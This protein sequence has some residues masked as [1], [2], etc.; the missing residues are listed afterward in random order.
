M[1][2]TTVFRV[3]KNKNYTTISNHHL[4]DKN[5][6]LKAKG[7]LTLILSL[8]PDWDMTLKGLVSLSG[9]GVDSVRSGIQELEK[10]GYLR[11]SRSRNTL[12]QLLCTEYTIYEQAV[13]DE[14]VPE[15]NTSK[16]NPNTLYTETTYIG[17]SD[18]DKNSQVGKSDVDE[19]AQIGKSD[20]AEKP[21]KNT[22]KSSDNQVDF[23]NVGKPN[24]GKTDTIKD[25]N[26]KDTDIINNSPSSKRNYNTESQNLKKKEMDAAQRLA[27]ERQQYELLVKANIDYDDEM[28]V[29]LA[30]RDQERA[31]FLNLVVD[32]IVD[33]IIST[34]PTFLIKKQELPAEAVKSRLLK[35]KT[36][37][38]DYAYDCLQQAKSKIINVPNYI[39]TV[40]YNSLSGSEIFYK[41]WVQH[42]E[43][44][45]AKE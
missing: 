19:N 36:A 25:L 39:L 12:G 30:A 23:S 8:P 24:I 38:I 14:S 22:E 10:N 44:Q 15:V 5:L 1:A 3:E 43:Y 9:D 6:S 37:H 2:T 45:R 11:R 29:C 16:E 42:D 13:K 31:D 26:N 35:I 4:Q 18:V 27:E 33:A 21:K 40:L 41:N 20:M 17:K 32:T 7:L 34:R 28:E